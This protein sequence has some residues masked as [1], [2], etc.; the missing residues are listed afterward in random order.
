M[1]SN[2]NTLFQ[3]HLERG[4]NGPEDGGE[5]EREE[6]EEGGE[7]QDYHLQIFTLLMN[8]KYVLLVKKYILSEQKYIS[9]VH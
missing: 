2:T 3:F 7:D 6:P 9:V 1:S 8:A 5:E 4:D